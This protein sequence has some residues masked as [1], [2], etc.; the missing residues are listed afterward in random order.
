[1]PFHFGHVAVIGKPNVGKSTLVNFMVGQHVSIVSNKP[2]TTRR[3]V[4][5]IVNGDNFQ[6]CLLDTPGIHEAHTVL[7]REMLD[8]A[9]ASLE[10]VDAVLYVTDVSHH[11]G[12]GDQ[13]I[14]ELLKTIAGKVPVVLALN[15]M[16]LLKADRVIPHVEAY[17]GLFGTEDYM[18]TV[19]NQGT[20]VEKLQEMIVSKIPEGEA[21]YDP[22]EFTDQPARFMV[23]E[24]I[25]EKILEATRQ[26]IPY[27]TAVQVE[28]W[29]Q[30]EGLL[31]IE[32]Q[33]LVEKS[34]QR[35]ILL[36]K[37][38][39]FIKQIGMESRKS[40]EQLLEQHVFLQLH[41]KVQEDWRMNVGTLMELEYRDVNR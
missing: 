15:K 37:G 1:M 28:S 20:H 4:M 12:N 24:I 33:I 19:A 41:V 36:G 34:S 30:E 29:E 16:D 23:A 8:A 6:M 7:G 38:G 26:E 18:L 3:R 35:A 31:R 40:V 25:R 22:D 27:A 11:P 2:Q 9:R 32:A 14:A 13:R 39:S 21:Q 5:G 10:G 17:C